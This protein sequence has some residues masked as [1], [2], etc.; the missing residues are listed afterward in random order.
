[1][2]T[3]SNA[4]AS[5]TS[6]NT[7]LAG[8]LQSVLV[9]LVDLHLQ[10]KQAHWNV[11]GPNF[12]AVHLH[13]DEIAAF[14]R[15]ASD[16]IAERIRAVAAAPDGRAGT[17]AAC[18]HLADF[19]S[20]EQDSRD[21]AARF[22]GQL[23]AAAATVRAVHDAVDTADPSSSDLLHGIIVGLEK[24]AWMLDAAGRARS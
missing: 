23:R 17:V 7:S 11:V 14:A 15:E 12:H 8:H 9:D 6:V 2:T 18:S 1:M 22:A 24:H 21:L 10:A 4:T 20:G 5:A 3:F 19:P 16:S 13:L